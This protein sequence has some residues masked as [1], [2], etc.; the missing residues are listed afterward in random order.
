MASNLEDYLNENYVIKDSTYKSTK[1]QIFC[2]I[3]HEI[4]IKPVMCMTCQKVFCKKCIEKWI[5]IKNFCPNKCTYY[6]EYKNSIIVGNILSKLNFN[7]KDCGQIINYEK[8]EKHILS[9]CD[10]IEIKYDLLNKKSSPDEGIFKKV[11]EK[12]KNREGMEQT[13]IKSKSYIYKY[14]I[15]NYFNSNLPWIKWSGQKFFNTKVRNLII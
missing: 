12:K 3:C 9:I 5:N 15:Y 13:N 2:Y 11:L 4:L 1:D 10:T 14:I 6:P 8:M 7:C